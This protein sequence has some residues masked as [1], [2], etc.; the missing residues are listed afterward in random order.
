MACR[1][2]NSGM[3]F[4]SIHLS[5]PTTLSI[6]SAAFLNPS[7]FLRSSAMPHSISVAEVSVPPA[8][9]SCVNAL[10]LLRLSLTSRPGS[11]ANCSRTSTMSFATK[12]STPFLCALCSSNTSSRKISNLLLHSFILLT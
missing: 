4:S 6:S 9:M 3:S 11:S 2:G 5:R 8:I 1:N 12:F 7:G 10:T